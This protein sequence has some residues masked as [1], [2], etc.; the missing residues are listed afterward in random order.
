MVRYGE[1]SSILL[2]SSP[3]NYVLCPSGNIKDCP[4]LFCHYFSIMETI[5]QNWLRERLRFFLH[6]TT[7]IYM[8]LNHLAVSLDPFDIIGLC[9][10]AV[11]F[12]I[13]NLFYQKLSDGRLCLGYITQSN[14]YSKSFLNIFLATQSIAKYCVSCIFVSMSVSVANYALKHH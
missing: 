3:R 5:S 11:W 7:G 14:I 2:V 1:F 6:F 10:N 9:S 8:P 13:L 4:N 12:E